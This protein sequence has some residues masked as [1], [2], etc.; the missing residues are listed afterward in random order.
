MAA[1]QDTGFPDRSHYV[2]AYGPGET[3]FD[4]GDPGEKLYVIQAGEV[5]LCRQGRSG[6]RTVARLGA[7]DF[8]GELSVVRGAA[9]TSQAVSVNRTRLIELE[10]E[11]L[12]SMCVAQPAI[13]IRMIRVL[14]SRLIEAER[15]LVDLGVDDI[16]RAVVRAVM[17]RAE[18]DPKEGNRVALDLRHLADEAGLSML[19]AHRAMHGLFERKLIHLENEQLCVPDLEALAA[20]VDGAA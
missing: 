1:P 16:R 11:A 18:P 10:R 20:S 17:R 4:A 19:E 2:R 13:A 6:R 7:G 12:E 5:E 3:I 9:C 14:V 15:R 8:F